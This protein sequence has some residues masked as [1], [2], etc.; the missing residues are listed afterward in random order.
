M[1]KGKKEAMDLA[2]EIDIALNT[3]SR[4]A[5][6]LLANNQNQKERRSLERLIDS[7]E[8]SKDDVRRAM[9]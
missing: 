6:I 3:T 7:I 1:K 4:Q 5:Y 8:R 9:L 2:I